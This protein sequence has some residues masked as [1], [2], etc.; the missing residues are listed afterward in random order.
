M[1][2]ATSTM[3]ITT[4][5]ADA[6]AAIPINR[7]KAIQ[8]AGAFGDF[9]VAQSIAVGTTTLYN[10]ATTPAMGMYIFNNAAAGSGITVVPVLTPHGGAAQTLAALQPQSGIFIQNAVNT[11][12]A[13][14]YDTIAVT[15]AGGTAIVEWFVDA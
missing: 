8:L 10:N 6:A 4:T 15:V 5:V 3:T 12:I 9:V 2:N 13:S 14:G 1:A 7:T 11:T